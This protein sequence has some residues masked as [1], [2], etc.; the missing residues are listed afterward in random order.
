MFDLDKTCLVIPDIHQHIRW[1]DT[2]LSNHVHE[3][4]QVVF[5]GDY[6]DPKVEQAASVE[7]TAVYLSNLESRLD[8]PATFLVGNHD[9]P[10]LFDLQ[11]PGGP[12]GSLRNPY[13]NG[14]YNPE[15]SFLLKRELSPQ[16]LAKLKPF[17]VFNGWILSHAGIHPSYFPEG[18]P[19]SKSDLSELHSELS[20]VLAKLPSPKNGTLANVGSAR[21]GADPVGGITWLDWHAEFTDIPDWPQIVGHTILQA[22]GSNNGNWNLDT[23]IGNYGIL[24]NEGLQVRSEAKED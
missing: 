22:P 1:A 19:I 20:Q 21:G 24:T 16:F 15:W 14:A 10:Y 13:S 4:D 23:K 11:Q 5:L 7:E 6:F 8:V 9:L 12:S 18:Q 17:T 3:V 2:I